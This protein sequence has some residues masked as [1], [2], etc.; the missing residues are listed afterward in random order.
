MKK[1]ESIWAELSAKAQEST[2]LSEVKVEL[3][4]VDELN[5]LEKEYFSARAQL[6][7]IRRIGAELKNKAKGAASDLSKVE[8][9]M[10]QELN[11]FQK[12]AEELGVDPKGIKEYQNLNRILND[13]IPEYLAIY[14][15]VAK[16]DT[17]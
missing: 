15:R 5:S 12:K 16:L 4:S 14:E 11:S 7:D 9:K 3:A 6:G 8:S 2:E 17:L 1:V 10:K 13:D